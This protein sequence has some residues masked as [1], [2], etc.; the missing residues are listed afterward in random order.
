MGLQVQL[1]FNIDVSLMTRTY[2]KVSDTVKII[3][4]ST[5]SVIV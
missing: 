3:I 2:E 1:T 5:W 4:C